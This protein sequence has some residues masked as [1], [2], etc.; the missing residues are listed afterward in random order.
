MRSGN[1]MW[2]CL[3]TLSLLTLN[4][5]CAS[6]GPPPTEPSFLAST[7][8]DD[9]YEYD[10]NNYTTDYSGSGYPTYTYDPCENW[11]ENLQQ[12]HYE[13]AVNT[14]FIIIT[15]PYNECLESHT[16]TTWYKEGVRY[17]WKN[18]ELIQQTGDKREKLDFRKVYRDDA[19]NYTC[20]MTNGTHTYTANIQLTTRDP[21]SMTAP[22]MQPITPTIAYRHPADNA[23][24]L[25]QANFGVVGPAHFPQLYWT[26]N[27]TFVDSSKTI[28]HHRTEKDGSLNMNNTLSLT[29]LREDDFGEYICI[30][31]T[32]FGWAQENATLVNGDPPVEFQDRIFHHAHPAAISC[33]LVFLLMVAVLVVLY[34]T[35]ELEIQLM[36]KDYFAQFEDDDYKICNKIRE[37]YTFDLDQLQGTHF[38]FEV[39]ASRDVRIALSNQNAPTPDMFE[40][41]IGGEWNARSLVRKQG[42]L[43]MMVA[44]QDI[45]SPKEWRR[46]WVTFMDGTLE[47]GR[48]GVLEPFL[49]WR[50][51]DLS[52]VKYVGYSSG[53]GD[54]V[55][56]KFADLGTKDHDVIILYD[57]AQLGFVLNTLRVFL[58]DTCNLVVAME[59]L[60]FEIGIDIA[61]NWVDFVEKARHCVIVLSPDFLRNQWLQFGFSVALER[62]LTRNSRI[63]IIEYETIQEMED[64]RDWKSLRHTMNAVKCIKWSDSDAHS[65]ASRFWKELRFQMPKKRVPSTI[66]RRRTTCTTDSN[67][68]SQNTLLSALSASEVESVVSHMPDII[69]VESE[70]VGNDRG[71]INTIPE[72]D[73]LTSLPEN[74]P[75]KPPLVRRNESDLSDNVFFPTGY[76]ITYL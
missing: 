32:T 18:T 17:K 36:W 2:L 49:R 68:S 5:S 74:V 61:E 46:F 70:T 6:V 48:Q 41:V 26:K 69:R 20:E 7:A 52:E 25:C 71:R 37:D 21:E 66:H 16:T 65:Q 72:R 23:T 62:M 53:S 54:K 59:D 15:C 76:E 51:P 45:L 38:S 8:A 11:Q 14:E 31:H 56:L 28:L 57:Q 42:S 35:W 50:D 12:L 58:E 10:Y 33:P 60:D 3:V 43:L 55:K 13:R 19:G 29:D 63:T 44:T 40:I 73:V 75:Y 47:V 24:F 30:A 27:N 39:R 22:I 9:Y 1:G 67:C 34:K 4:S 64:F